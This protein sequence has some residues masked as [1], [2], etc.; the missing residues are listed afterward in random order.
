MQTPR[1]L[2]TFAAFLS[3]LEAAGI[4]YAVI[5]GCAVGAYARL[6]GST[7]TTVDLDLYVTDA[8]KADLLAWAP[9][10][11]VEVVKRPRPRSLPV[12]VLCWS[13]E[14]INAL[15]QSAGLPDPE[16]VART[17]REVELREAAV[18]ARVADPFDLLANK[19]AVR[20]PKDLPHIEVLTRFC[21]EEA[22]YAFEVEATPRGRIA[23]LRRLL[24]VLGR[25]TLSEVLADRGSRALL[26]GGAPSA[27]AA[28]RSPAPR[29]PRSSARSP[30]APA[31]PSPRTAARPAAPPP[32]A[33][34]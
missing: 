28:S 31:P 19:L 17:A 7:I 27:A 20:R 11:G 24:R 8:A 33:P 29:A 13:G 22:T 10:N 26:S 12:A 30:P 3:A 23:P 25:E 6:V 34:S 1:D 14:E 18:V 21:E 15:T 16:V 2:T 32:T 4:D 9:D 5:G